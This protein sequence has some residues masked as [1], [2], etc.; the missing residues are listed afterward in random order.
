MCYCIIPQ[1]KGYYMAPMKHVMTSGPPK[2]RTVKTE[3]SKVYQYT[4]LH[5]APSPKQ[6]HPEHTP[7]K[8][9]RIRAYGSQACPLLG[10][11][12]IIGLPQSHPSCKLSTN[13]KS[14]SAVTPLTEIIN[15]FPTFRSMQWWLIQAWWW[16]CLLRFVLGKSRGHTSMR[17]VP[18]S[19]KARHDAPS[20]WQSTQV[21]PALRSLLG[22]R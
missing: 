18:V 16:R 1:M 15:C 4:A 17:S 20:I 2:G 9:Q 19:T 21:P 13:K 11:R 12:A 8:A 3:F 14:W 22:K 10:G 6:M 5:K 7:L